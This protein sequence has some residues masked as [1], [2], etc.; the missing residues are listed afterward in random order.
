MTQKDKYQLRELLLT[1]A[2]LITSAFL[3]KPA[4][5]W[6]SQLFL[7]GGAIIGLGFDWYNRKLGI[8]GLKYIADAAVLITLTWIGYRIF[9]SSFLYKEV[10]TIFIQGIIVL[11]V[12]FSFIFS[13]PR[14]KI[15]LWLLSLLIFM[16]SP[17]FAV[18]YNITLAIADLLVWLAVLRFQFSG[19]LQPVPT[20]DAQRYY[21]LAAS[22]ACFLVVIFLAWLVVVL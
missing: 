11:E 15:Y 17:I 4:V 21:S 13:A 10:I 19:F 16:T 2:L 7:F 14:R 20:K 6:Q 22:L 3:L 18:T 1:F 9:K 5:F 8:A 12:I